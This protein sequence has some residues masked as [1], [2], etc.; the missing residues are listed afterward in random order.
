MCICVYI[1][2]QLYTYVIFSH[3]NQ[4][5]A[6]TRW[7]PYRNNINKQIGISTFFDLNENHAEPYSV[8]LEELDNRT[9]TLKTKIKQFFI[10]KSTR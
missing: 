6:V 8:I 10:T 2:F 9:V 7:G 5:L 3:K 4:F 1:I